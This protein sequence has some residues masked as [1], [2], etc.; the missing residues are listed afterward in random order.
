MKSLKLRWTWD[1]KGL[2]PSTRLGFN[3]FSDF[4]DVRIS[5]TM[6]TIFFPGNQMEFCTPGIHHHVFLGGHEPRKPLIFCKCL[7]ASGILKYFAGKF[8][9]R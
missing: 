2:K 6:G 9:I 8:T 5:V 3:I 7:S 1:E 4:V